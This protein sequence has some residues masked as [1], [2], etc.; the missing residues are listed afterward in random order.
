MIGKGF[1]QG[2]A[3][4]C[5]LFAAANTYAHTNSVGFDLTDLG[6]GSCTVEW[7]YGSWHSN[8]GI[9]PE[10]AFSLY[11]LGSAAE[12]EAAGFAS[13]TTPDASNPNHYV[14]EAYG[15]GGSV[16]NET[17]YFTWP[18]KNT[19]TIT[20]NSNI[21]NTAGAQYDEDGVGG[22]QNDI[23]D[24]GFVP[25]K[26]YFFANGDGTLGTVSGRYQQTY[27][28][29]SSTITE[30][31]AGTFRGYYDGKGAWDSTN[32]PA[33]TPAITMNFEPVT[34]IATALFT[35]AGGC[36]AIVGASPQ[37]LINSVDNDNGFSSNDFVTSGKNTLLRGFFNSA[38]VGSLTLSITPSGGTATTYDVSDTE[39]TTTGDDWVLNVGDLNYG[40][41]TILATVTDI[42][43]GSTT[44]TDSLDLDIIAVGVQSISEDNGISAVDFETSDTT[45]SISGIWASS[46][47]TSLQVVFNGTTYT[48]SDSELTT[49]GDV[50]TLDATG[51]VLTAGSYTVAASATLDGNT[52][53]S[54]KTID[55]VEAP[56]KPTIDAISEDSGAAGDFVTTD[57]TLSITGT[58]GAASTS[59]LKIT[60]AGIIYTLG[61]SSELT[62]SNDNWTLDLTG[63]DLGLGTFNISVD[64][65]N[66][67]GILSRTAKDIQI[68]GD[69]DGDGVSDD[70]DTDD[71]GDGISDEDEI[72]AGTNPNSADSD[73]DGLTDAEELAAGTN[74]T[75]SDSDGDGVTDVTDNFPLADTVES[76]TTS[77]GVPISLQ[78]T[79]ATGSSSC[80][81]SSGMSVN[82][83]TT[84][85]PGRAK[86]G[87]GLAIS[88]DMT[89]CS[90]SAVQ[91]VS[92]ATTDGKEKIT[93]SIDLGTTPIPEGA[94]AFK[95]RGNDWS[96]IPG[97]TIEG[98]VV[99]YEIVDNGPLDND[100]D[101]GDISDPVTVAI[102]L[103]AP[104]L[105]VPT[106]SGLALVLLSLMT[107][108]IGRRRLT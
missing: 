92:G 104:A 73:G 94:V 35:V 103:S 60:V 46:T 40:S 100:P 72:A 91:L 108:I 5:S 106:L 44:H 28:H 36:R 98:S 77:N 64:A 70:V 29:Q 14:H 12:L 53:T 2:A 17:N 65:L 89:G 47:A 49:N 33:S 51:I 31:G 84:E 9:G 71:D 6:N 18:G 21:E 20:L 41:Y 59:T 13:G 10:G 68:V 79:P 69:T 45:L 101:L 38:V 43:D 107:L 52:V 96:E 32:P 66:A 99:T 39:L 37:V 4:A 102:P 74:P 30:V 80:S 83:I 57:T 15:T 86:E 56:A 78:T 25:G 61:S 90:N 27:S 8:L 58:Y 63:R 93:I 23:E 82:S 87:I 7:Y 50:W 105:P 95:V 24:T 48:Q 88:F 81:L 75:N 85:V 11:T 19:G 54:S 3:L 16:K 76:A 97:A 62:A 67:N 22:T 1:I 55:V 26:T 42:S 34:S